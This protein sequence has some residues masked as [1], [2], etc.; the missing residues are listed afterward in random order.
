VITA[1]LITTRKRNSKRIL[2]QAGNPNSRVDYEEEENLLP[3]HSDRSTTGKPAGPFQFW[4][5]DITFTFNSDE[6]LLHY[7]VM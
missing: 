1:V 2:P 3:A 5:T 6:H 4:I 7:D